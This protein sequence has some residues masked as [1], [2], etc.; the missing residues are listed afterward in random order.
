[1]TD[2]KHVALFGGSFNPPHVCHTL[3]TLW[4]LQTQAVD[5]VWWIP[6]YQH[7]FNKE[8]ASFEAREAMCQA[9]LHSLND[10]RVCT[11]ERELGGESRTIDT[12]SALQERYPQTRFSLVIGADIL[13]EVDR[14]KRWDD[15]MTM[16][17]LIVVGRRGHDRDTAPDTI[18]LELPDISSTIIRDA[19]AACDYESVR[20]W[21]P[22]RVLDI[23][24]EHR[25]Y[26]GSRCA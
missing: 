2:P 22:A 13:S 24:S 23:V 14:W 20:A 8:L 3:A 25:L 26:L 12:V 15:L 21:I 18:D 1:M 17:D 11:I 6:T 7:A 5:E 10:V 9:A 4:V 16:V 19:L